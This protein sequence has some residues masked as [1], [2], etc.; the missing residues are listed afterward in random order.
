M[1]LSANPPNQNNWGILIHHRIVK[2]LVGH[3]QLVQI[4]NIQ[5]QMKQKIKYQIKM[6]QRHKIVHPHQKIVSLRLLMMI[7]VVIQNQ[8]LSLRI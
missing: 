1:N 6:F 2:I 5:K 7:Q 4:P 3:H 8:A